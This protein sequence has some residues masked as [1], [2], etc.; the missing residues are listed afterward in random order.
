[1]KF[2]LFVRQIFQ[3]HFLVVGIDLQKTKLASAVADIADDLVGT[4]L[5]D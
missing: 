4:S 3:E 2:Q 1:M 5:D